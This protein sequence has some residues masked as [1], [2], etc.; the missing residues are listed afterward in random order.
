MG[1][2][3]KVFIPVSFYLISPFG[4]DVEKLMQFSRIHAVPFR[5]AGSRLQ[6]ELC[7]RVALAHVHVQRFSRKAFI[8]IEEERVAL[9]V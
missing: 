9:S 4:R 8:R 7:N 2:A 5:H 3:T 1:S 6:P